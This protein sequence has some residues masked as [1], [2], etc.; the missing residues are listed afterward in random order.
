[1]IVSYPTQKRYV[2]KYYAAMTFPKINLG[3]YVLKNQFAPP[4]LDSPLRPCIGALAPSIIG[5]L[6]PSIIGALVP[7]IIGAL[8]PSIIGAFVPK[9]G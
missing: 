5:T 1:M 4:I 3:K 2:V 6:V 8:V 7:S 9:W